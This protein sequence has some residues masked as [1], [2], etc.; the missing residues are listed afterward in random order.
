MNKQTRPARRPALLGAALVSVFAL[1]GCEYADLLSTPSDPYSGG[2][3]APVGPGCGYP[4]A[5]PPY[6]GG[7][8]F[9]GYGGGCR[10]PVYSRVTVLSARWQS[11]RRG[12]DVTMLVQDMLD[13]GTDTFK[14]D[15]RTFGV[16]PDKGKHK[17]LYV[18]YRARGETRTLV[19]N[20]G[21]TVRIR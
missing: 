21:E 19:V 12:A 11:E 3:S 15:N 4:P 13:R 16:D 14:A 6:G 18:R 10:P 8:G 9:G 5:P 7:Y 2:Y 1:T 17:R 20:E